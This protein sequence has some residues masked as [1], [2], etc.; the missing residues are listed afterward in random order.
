M[1]IV[2]IIAIHEI[3]DSTVFVGPNHGK[4]VRNDFECF[5]DFYEG[6]R[7]FASFYEYFRSFSVRNLLHL[8]LFG[9]FLDFEF[10]RRLWQKNGRRR[11]ASERGAR[12]RE[13]R[14]E[15][16]RLVKIVNKSEFFYRHRLLHT[17]RVIVVVVTHKINK[18]A[19][20]E[21]AN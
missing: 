10:Q 2:F 16:I 20:T 5:M 19:R 14:I 18:G 9:I 3:L 11:C 15:N 21:Y 1:A 17:F 6:K 13:G 8:S 4:T 7:Y 12:F